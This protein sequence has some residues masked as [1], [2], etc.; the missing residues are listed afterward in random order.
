MEILSHYLSALACLSRSP[1]PFPPT[2]LSPAPQSARDSLSN[3]PPTAP[4]PTQVGTGEGILAYLYSSLCI[5]ISHFVLTIFA[6]GGWG[7]IAVSSLIAHTL[8]RSFPPLVEDGD[9]Q[10]IRSRRLALAQLAKQSQMPRHS[11][12]GHA[13]TAVGAFRRAMTKPEQLAVYVEVVR[14]A[15]WLEM[16]RKEASATREVLKLVGAVVVEGREEHK[17]LL[18][19]AARAQGDGTS[20]MESALGYG[21]GVPVAVQQ[22]MV[23]RRKESSDGNLGIAELI[24]R[25]CAVLGVDLLALND[26]TKE[27]EPFRPSQDDVGEPHFGWPD[28]QVEVIKEAITIAEALPGESCSGLTYAYTT[29]QQSVV[30]L[31]LSALHSLYAHLGQSSQSQLAKLYV[32]A[33]ST[34]RRR[35]VEIGPLPWWLPGRMV[36]S[37]EIS[38]LATNKIP[39]EHARAEIAPTEK[40]GAKDPFLYN[41]RLKAPEPGKTVLV[42]NEQV[43]VFVTIQNVFAIDLEIQDLSLL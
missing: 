16:E 30:R 15:R 41:P 40:Q 17:R 42:A 37:V 9:Q 25:I 29:D 3:P 13:E 24:D 5:R 43:D 8:P 7:S 39:F 21:L 19:Q 14:L 23:A 36:L 2:I 26:P 12:L 6:A 18:A 28:L 33:I 20:K 27:Y 31:C 4:S 22:V 32:Q 11:I 1:L 35:A 34:L 38:S 10:R